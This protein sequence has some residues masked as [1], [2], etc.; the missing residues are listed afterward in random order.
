MHYLDTSVSYYDEQ[1]FK[2]EALNT[3]DTFTHLDT[4]HS[5]LKLI[6]LSA[7]HYIVTYLY[8]LELILT[9]NL[10]GKLHFITLIGVH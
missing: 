4:R 10:L 6:Q 9:G 7:I 3:L 2:A 1:K 5:L 8:L